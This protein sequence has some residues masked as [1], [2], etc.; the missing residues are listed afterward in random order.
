[1]NSKAFGRNFITIGSVATFFIIMTIAFTS[2]SKKMHFAQSTVV[3]AAEGTVKWKKDKN[4]NYSVDASIIRLAEPN[5]LQPPKRIYVLWMNTKANGI[6]NIGQLKSSTGLLSKTLKASLN[7]VTS[8][9]P[10]S[11]FITAEDDGSIP[12]PGSQVILT[13]N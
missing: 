13:T 12:Y 5:R 3:P 4:G 8:F 9:E 6:K 2:C 7:T 1:M 11:F 10:V